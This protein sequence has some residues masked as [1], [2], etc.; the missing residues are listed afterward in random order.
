[1]AYF[2]A[3]TQAAGELNRSELNRGTLNRSELNRGELNRGELNRGELN[4][5]PRTH[6]EQTHPEAFIMKLLKMKAE[7]TDT[8]LLTKPSP[9]RGASQR[10]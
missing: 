8:K 2:N 4:R 3:R 9:K 1:M 6:P 10:S 7:T 5:K